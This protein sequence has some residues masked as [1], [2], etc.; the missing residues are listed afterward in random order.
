MNAWN[1]IQTQTLL[2]K[3]I[4]P[5]SEEM[6]HRDHATQA[7][8]R[9][10]FCIKKKEKRWAFWIHVFLDVERELEFLEE[11]DWRSTLELAKRLSAFTN[12]WISVIGSYAFGT[13]TVCLVACN[14]KQFGWVYLAPAQ[15]WQNH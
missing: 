11:L 4:C 2:N 8:L 6:K 15:K 12:S 3:T 14:L 7:H 13:N 9:W 1:E 5:K 10:A